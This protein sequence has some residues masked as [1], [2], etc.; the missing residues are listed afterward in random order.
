VRRDPGFLRN[1][2][3]IEPFD[4]FDSLASIADEV[5]MALDVALESSR[6]AGYAYFPD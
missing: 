1:L 3:E 5:M 4:I 2:L 6:L